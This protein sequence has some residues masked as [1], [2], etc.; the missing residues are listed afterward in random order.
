LGISLGRGERGVRR[1]ERERREKGVDIAV[2]VV[3]WFS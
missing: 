1:E 3:V 2:S